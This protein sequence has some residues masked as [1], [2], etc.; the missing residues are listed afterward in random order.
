MAPAGYLNWNY[1]LAGYPLVDDLSH[2]WVFITWD[3]SRPSYGDSTTSVSALY[4]RR[5]S[6]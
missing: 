2:V 1:I 5:L 3:I 4:I 6:S